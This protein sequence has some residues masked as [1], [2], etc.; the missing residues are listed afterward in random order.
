MLLEGVDRPAE[1][2][3]RLLFVEVLFDDR[4]LVVDELL[5]LDVPED[6]VLVEPSVEV[7]FVEVLLP[8]E[9]YDELPAPDET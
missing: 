7:L 4:P 1:L 9:P 6:D 2:P 5:L 8:V 3:E